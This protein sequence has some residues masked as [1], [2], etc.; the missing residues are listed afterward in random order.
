[1]RSARFARFARNGLYTRSRIPTI[2]SWLESSYGLQPNLLLGNQ[3]IPS[4]GGVQQGDPLGPLGFALVLH[5][6]IEK[7]RESVPGLLINVWYLDDGTLCG[8]QQDL[9]AALAI[10]EA[11][12]PPRGLF[13][14]RVKSFIHSPDTVLSP[15]PFSVASPPP[16]TASLFWD[17][18]LAQTLSVRTSFPRG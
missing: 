18:Q 14:N 7:I 17:P 15:I 11:E 4:C 13:L 8:T 1:M 10:I 5:P 3:T 16:Q 12:G 6:I 2:S 9:A